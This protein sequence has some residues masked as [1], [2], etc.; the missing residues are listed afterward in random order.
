MQAWGGG[1]EGEEWN[2]EL[3]VA[4]SDNP[5]FNTKGG[6]WK[7][8]KAQN[9]DRRNSKTESYSFNSARLGQ[10]MFILNYVRKQKYK[11]DL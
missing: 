1:G 7:K 9:T 3:S 2:Q 8:K 10:I 5:Y 4:V 11:F 6:I